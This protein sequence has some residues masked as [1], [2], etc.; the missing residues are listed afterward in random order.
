MDLFSPSFKEVSKIIDQRHQWCKLKSRL[1]QYFTRNH[2]FSEKLCKT[3]S[4]INCHA[5]WDKLAN[6]NPANEIG[7]LLRACYHTYQPLQL[8][9]ITPL[10]LGTPTTC[11]EPQ[12][13]CKNGDSCII[14]VFVGYVS[15]MSNRMHRLWTF[16]KC[17]WGLSK[18]KTGQCAEPIAFGDT[19]YVIFIAQHI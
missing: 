13:F 3:L 8:V 18:L 12:L 11:T 9:P 2:L 7:S 16:L 19:S 14:F 17:S 4:Y 5:Y 6:D 15:L 1:C 10:D